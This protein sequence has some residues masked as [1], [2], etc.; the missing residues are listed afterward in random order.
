MKYQKRFVD[1]LLNRKDTIEEKN[2]EDI[3]KNHDKGCMI[4]KNEFTK[5]LDE[6]AS[7]LSLE[8]LEQE[9]LIKDNIL[10]R[11]EVQHLKNDIEQLNKILNRYK[12]DEK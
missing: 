1:K 7:E 12:K 11:L 2:I 6:L 8:G 4:Q 10:L 3:S 9:T 5:E